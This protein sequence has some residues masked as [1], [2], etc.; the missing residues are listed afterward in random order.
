MPDALPMPSAMAAGAAVV[1]QLGRNAELK[2]LLGSAAWSG[3]VSDAAGLAGML[4]LA[5]SL[6]D[7][8]PSPAVLV[9]IPWWACSG[10]ALGA[11]RSPARCSSALAIV[12]LAIVVVPRLGAAPFI[13]SRALG[14]VLLVGAVLLIRR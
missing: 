12:G 4:L 6:R 8:L 3:V 11:V 2:A 5:A 14:L 1:A 9:R 7:P 13:G 10:G